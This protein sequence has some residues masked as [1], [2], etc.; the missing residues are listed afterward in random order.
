MRVPSLPTPSLMFRASLFAAAALAATG[1]SAGPPDHE[2]WRCNTEYGQYDALDAGVWD[3]TTTVT[4]EVIFKNAN[5]GP[6]WLPSAA[7]GFTDSARD[8]GGCQCNG[9]R[10]EA[11]DEQPGKLLLIMT[12][13]GEDRAVGWYAAGQPLRFKLTFNDA[14]RTV[15]LEAAGMQMTARPASMTRNQMHLSCSSAAVSFRN[16]DPE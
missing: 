8:A 15:K 9:L 12:V 4:G 6:Q 11:R 13:D 3:K 7:V 16:L 10:V 2:S 5:P 14:A 1:S